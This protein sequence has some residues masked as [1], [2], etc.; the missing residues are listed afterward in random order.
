MSSNVL[1]LVVQCNKAMKYSYLSKLLVSSSQLKYLLLKVTSV[2][3]M[4][5]F[6]DEVQPNKGC[7][8]VRVQR[9]N[10]GNK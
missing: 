2:A 10:I 8:S 9:T 3:I 6:L 4:Q 5:C 1:Q 7:Y